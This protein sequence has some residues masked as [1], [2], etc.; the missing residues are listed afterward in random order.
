ML[1]L[2]DMTLRDGLQSFPKIISTAKKLNIYKRIANSGINAIEF[3]SNVSP[4]IT[5]M[6]DFQNLL[7]GISMYHSHN[8]LLY[9]PVNV[10]FIK[11][12]S[13]YAFPPTLPTTV[14]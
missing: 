13:V 8:K 5:Q 11:G 10:N 3:G 2:C 9:K 14:V 7:K 6:A 1:R 12:P 4:K